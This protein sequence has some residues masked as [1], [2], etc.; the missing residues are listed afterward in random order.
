MKKPK[1]VKR[2]EALS[3]MLLAKEEAEAERYIASYG[4]E[5]NTILK[6]GSDDEISNPHY[7][8]A[9]AVK[10]KYPRVSALVS[11]WRWAVY[12]WSGYSV[13]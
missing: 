3:D 2:L 6:Y 8:A 4:D 7:W 9:S 5:W 11:R 12:A 10:A 1:F 13:A